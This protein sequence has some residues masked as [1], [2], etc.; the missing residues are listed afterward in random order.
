MILTN[1][2]SASIHLP[3]ETPDLQLYQP[4]RRRDDV[5]FRSVQQGFVPTRYLAVASLNF[6]V[7]IPLDHYNT[8]NTSDRLSTT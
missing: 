6:H 1:I 2:I 5:A 8:F 7:V 4:V 3:T